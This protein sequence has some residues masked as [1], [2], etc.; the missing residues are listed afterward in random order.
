M[1]ALANYHLLPAVHGDLLEKLGRRAE[2][3]AA[4]LQAAELAGNARE[5]AVMQQRAK[6]CA[7]A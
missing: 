2:A 3:R 7:D 5:Q 6:A 1:S 4:F